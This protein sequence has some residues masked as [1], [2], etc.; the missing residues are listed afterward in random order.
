MEDCLCHLAGG[1]LVP[2][3]AQPGKFPGPS[4]SDGPVGSFPMLFSEHD[5][6]ASSRRVRQGSFLD[7][8][9]RV[10]PAPIRSSVLVVIWNLRKSQKPFFGVVRSL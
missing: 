3:H 4:G 8:F 9:C 10:P 6:G 2:P 1:L 7:D 5:N